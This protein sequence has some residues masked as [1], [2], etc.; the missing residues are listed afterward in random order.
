MRIILGLHPKQNTQKLRSGFDTESQ[1]FGTAK[2]DH[3]R[4]YGANIEVK[5]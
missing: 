3:A 1:C 5:R 4:I 2:Q